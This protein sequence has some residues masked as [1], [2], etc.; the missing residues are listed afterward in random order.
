[1]NDVLVVNTSFPEIDHLAAELAHAGLLSK[2]VRPYANT[3]RRWEQRLEASLGGNAYVRT[4]GRRRLP[5]PLDARHLDESGLI[6]DFLLAT[7]R[8]LPSRL[9]NRRSIEKAIINM[10]TCAIARRAASKLGVERL[11]LASF[12]CAELAFQKMKIQGGLTVLNYPI[13]HHRFTR[14][15]LLQE[16]KLQPAFAD[17]L[18]GHNYPAWLEQRL[19]TEIE[20]A[21]KILV[22]SSFVRDSFVV[23]GVSPKKLVIIP[24]GADTT[25]F[26][27]LPLRHNLQSEDVFRLL[28]VGQIGQRKGISYLLEAYDRFKD[29]NTSLTLVGS[30]QGSQ[31]IYAPWK[32]SFTHIPHLPRQSLP[33]IYRQADV[34]VF[35][36]LV[37]GLGIVVIEAMASG[38]PVI[39]TPN[40]PGDIVRD[41]IDGFVVP[42]RDV[43]AILRRL[44][45]LRDD[46][47]LRRR[48]GQNARQ[49]ALSF[50]WA[51]YRKRAV[52]Y[53]EQMLEE[54]R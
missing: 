15:Y 54:S 6:C 22:G 8:Y 32:Q 23:E 46:P 34:F 49:R 2:Y 36:T 25:L 3:G 21:D 33:D 9:I 14:R 28:F 30:L 27:P 26:E 5:T 31:D 1:M 43:D 13:A 20:L 53:I 18:S 42:V 39:T 48:M 10:R 17:T 19:D 24:Y 38:L 29:A 16:A 35:P 37:E 12:G 47:E 41:G 52:S 50:T 11:V 7:Q 51:A 4:F 44:C 45:E 40:G